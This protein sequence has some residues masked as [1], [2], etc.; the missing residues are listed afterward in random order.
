MKELTASQTD[1]IQRL[2]T[3]IARLGL[4]PVAAAF[5]ESVRPLNFV[6]NQML[7]F[8]APV[9]HTFGHFPDY[10]N[11]TSLL[12]NRESIP[13]LIEAIEKAEELSRR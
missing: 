12:E 2:A 8:C 6:A 1:L 4:A 13:A 11:L 5:L 3:R 7:H 10:E 9:V